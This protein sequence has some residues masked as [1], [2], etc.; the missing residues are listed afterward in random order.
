[1]D[2]GAVNQDDLPTLTG[3]LLQR[4]VQAWCLRGEQGDRLVAPVTDGGLGDVVADG[5]VGQALIVA[6][7]GQD[8]HRDPPGRQ[9][10]LPGDTPVT[11]TQRRPW[12]MASWSQPGGERAVGLFPQPAAVDQS[13][14][15]PRGGSSLLLTLTSIPSTSPT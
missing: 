4:A 15:F 3:D 10:P 6:Q 8:D 9:D 5:H 14:R 12:A 11:P 2:E 1:M 13:D 7:H